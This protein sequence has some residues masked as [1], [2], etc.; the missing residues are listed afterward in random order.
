MKKKAYI[1]IT[2]TPQARHLAIAKLFAFKQAIIRRAERLRRYQALVPDE[3]S[4]QFGF[5]LRSELRNGR[6]VHSG[7]MFCIADTYVL[8]HLHELVASGELL[9]NI[10]VVD[11]RQVQR[12]I[13][14][15]AVW[16][17]MNGVGNE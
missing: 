8:H 5:M 11:C 16:C 9:A 17:A 12:K 2:L 3:F 7:F 6:R 13:S 15:L 10:D 4:A 1:E 14:S